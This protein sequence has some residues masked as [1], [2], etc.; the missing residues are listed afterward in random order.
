MKVTGTKNNNN[1]QGWGLGIL[2]LG[3]T[4]ATSSPINLSIFYLP[5]FIILYKKGLNLVEPNSY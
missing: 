1:P 4:T 3:L 5:Y 2:P